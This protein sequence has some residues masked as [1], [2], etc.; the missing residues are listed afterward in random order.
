MSAFTAQNDLFDKAPARRALFGDK[1]KKAEPAQ[2][3]IEFPGG[4]VEVS[5]LDD[6]S[7]WAHIIINRRQALADLA[8]GMGSAFGKVIDSRVDWDER[9]L[10]AIPS[11]PDAA[12]LTQIAV[13][14]IP[15]GEKF[16]GAQ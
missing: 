3:I 1:K 2:H 4:A 13:R 14:I 15:E 12:N 10:E 8:P 9:R 11:L 7:Y 16:G 5:R 6:G